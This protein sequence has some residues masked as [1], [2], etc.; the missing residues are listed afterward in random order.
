MNEIYQQARAYLEKQN[1]QAA[2]PLLLQAARADKSAGEAWSDLAHILKM[3]KKL[4]A[5]LVCAR[6]AVSL[7]PYCSLALT[8][9]G[10]ILFQMHRHSEARP[11]LE[12]A[13]KVNPQAALAWFNLTHIYSDAGKF[14]K[15]LAA[16][17]KVVE[18]LP[19]QYEAKVLKS[20][21]LLTAGRFAEGWEKS[22]IRTQGEPGHSFPQ[23]SCPR[24]QGENLAGKSLYLYTEQGFGDSFQFIRYL[25][26]LPRDIRQIFV[27]APS[28][29]IRLF[30][31][32]FQDL[33]CRFIAKGETRPSADYH[34]PL[35]SLPW[36]LGEEANFIELGK[37]PYL[38]APEKAMA[39][40]ITTS[41]CLKVGIC[42]AG[43]PKHP[44]DHCRSAS[45]GEF[46]EELLVPGIE[47][48][49]VQREFQGIDPSLLG[50][51]GVVQD[52]SHQMMDFADT[53]SILQQLDM[54]VTVDTS[55]AH[56]AGA[57]GR[58]THLLLP[59]HGLDWRWAG[60]KKFSLWYPSVRLHRRHS[61]D[62][63]WRPVLKNVRRQIQRH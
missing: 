39:L 54:V 18:L 4:S 48:F 36:H 17:D 8:N 23:L 47:L 5:A 46:C 27:E 60:Q 30:E 20:L 7:R 45:L 62:S 38:S 57:L 14:R 34:T 19:D 33:P 49:S 21:T 6:H 63:S 15:A 22:E 32:S 44:N 9:L 16:A 26:A 43:N 61:E 11:Y 35:L 2:Y 42:W 37:R 51:L 3:E 52:L 10:D 41:A 53:A 13:V 1:F 12:M 29:V 40:P 56:L 58:P 31:N 25:R 24:W 50:P 55:I 59:Y 28:P